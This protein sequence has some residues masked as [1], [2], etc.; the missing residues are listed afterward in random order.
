M[1]MCRFSSRKERNG[2]RPSSWGLKTPLPHM[3]WR[4]TDYPSRLPEAFSLWSSK[5]MASYLVICFQR[6][7]FLWKRKTFPSLFF[8]TFFLIYRRVCIFNCIMLNKG[9]VLFCMLPAEKWGDAARQTLN[10]AIFPC[11]LGDKDTGRDVSFRHLFTIGGTA[12]ILPFFSRGPS[13]MSR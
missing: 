12:V 9:R 7:L 3:E 6:Y 8:E 13:K 4:Y 5:Q 2:G 1:L 11:V 10:K